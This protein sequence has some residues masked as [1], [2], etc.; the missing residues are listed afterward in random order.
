MWRKDTQKVS[1]GKYFNVA[2]NIWQQ[3]TS[4]FSYSDYDEG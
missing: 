3:L 1:S 2:F 4:E